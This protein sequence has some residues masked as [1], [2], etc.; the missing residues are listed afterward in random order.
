MKLSL[1]IPAYNDPEG[2]GQLL[3]QVRDLNIFAEV[4]VI[5]DAS[6]QRSDPAA[7]GIDPETLPFTLKYHRVRKNRGAG[8]ARN[9]GLSL[10]SGTHV[11]FFD[12]D[13]LFTAGFPR[14]V[15]R[16]QGRS[17]DFCIFKHVDSRVRAA[18]GYGLLPSDED[19]WITAG[20]TGALGTLTVEGAQTLCTVA[21]Y[22]WNKIYDVDFLRKNAIQCTEI[23]V[24]NDIEIHWM[25]F[26]HAQTILYSDLVCCE[27][28]VAKGR[29][30]LTNKK[31]R[32]RFTVT[33]ALTNVHLTF[34]LAPQT[35][36]F[37]V[38]FTSFYVGL[39]EWIQVQLEPDL[40]LPFRALAQ[41]FLRSNLSLE[42][43]TKVTDADPALGA[44]INQILKG[45][46]L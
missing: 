35:R 12:S 28:F 26:L 4:I 38:P 23:P 37:M 16:L 13:D 32:E 18:G 24:H 36:P 31:V 5:D 44:R 10:C 8:Y 20:A 42:Q 22:P 43:Y 34:D 33:E 3:A 17:F 21:A 46:R 15:S 19:R 6:D 1:V 7:L 41:D 14:L 2:V 11:L 45:Q 29:D 39:F 9:K 25:G 30:R 27:H 40:Q